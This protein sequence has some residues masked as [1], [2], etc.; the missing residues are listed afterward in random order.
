MP[1]CDGRCAG[2]CPPV[3]Y[4]AANGPKLNI[5]GEIGLAATTIGC[6][7]KI[8]KLIIYLALM[9]ITLPTPP[10]ACAAAAPV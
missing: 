7:A 9:S 10:K 3:G 2:K 5:S 6:M 1:S 8:S 4:T